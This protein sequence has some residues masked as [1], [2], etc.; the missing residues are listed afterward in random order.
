MRFVTVIFLILV[1]NLIHSLDYK[2]G[3]LRNVSIKKASIFVNKSHYSLRSSNNSLFKKLGPENR[4]DVVYNNEK[5]VLKI[6]DKYVGKF[7]TLKI[8]N[9]NKDTG[10]FEIKGILPNFKSRYYYDNLTIY[11]QSNS[12]S[13]VNNID[14]EKCIIGVLESEVGL[15][16]VKIFIKYTP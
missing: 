15:G 13:F 11:P 3:I 2:V 5:I 7:D 12:I 8:Y 14:F 10:I 9:L 1:S 4:V 6:D 16:K